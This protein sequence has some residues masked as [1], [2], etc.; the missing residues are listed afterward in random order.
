MKNLRFFRYLFLN[1][2]WL[3]NLW[4]WSIG[5][6]Q[7]AVVKA[8][9][10]YSPAC[11]HCK[12][13]MTKD[14]P[15]LVDKYGPQLEILAINK[16]IPEGRALYDA[17][18]LRFNIPKNRR[19]VPT[20]IVGDVVLVGSR[21]IPKKFPGLIRQFLAQG[22]V[23]WPDVPGLIQETPTPQPSPT[24]TLT[25]P[26]DIATQQPS[27][28]AEATLVSVL[29]VITATMAPSPTSIDEAL[30]ALAS[31][32]PS[33]RDK[34]MQDP[35]GNLLAIVVMM[36][37]ILAVILSFAVLPNIST[38][39]NRTRL[40]VLIPLLALIG[41]GVAGYL[42]YVETT[43]VMAICGPVG[44]CNT[45]QQS[46]YARLFGFLPIGALGLAG[47]LAI[48]AAWPAYYYRQ[49]SWKNLAS[50]ALF[51][52]TFFGTLFSIYLTFLEPFVIGATC[53]WCLSSSIIMT[54]LYL[55]TLPAG[56]RAL[57]HL[58]H[59]DTYADKRPSDKRS[60]QR[61]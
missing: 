14:L 40:D 15:W 18:V 61:L 36:G 56:K 8:V 17:A 5:L 30:I 13:V 43:Q 24:E 32:P 22:G 49:D 35:I 41:L 20:L 46:P 7:T 48:L 12:K 39:K 9:L 2:I 10:F 45:V 29:P 16:T 21:E 47:Y 52:M 27:A 57:I 11:P 1:A 38:A 25:L 34:L 51:A 60:S 26:I 37:M 4:P 55:L 33:L 28:T 19:G 50:M 59:G 54:A 58:L 23:D 42:T 44:D 6:A 31:Q 3:I 53:A